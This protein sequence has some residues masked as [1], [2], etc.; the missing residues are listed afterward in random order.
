MTSP[1]VFG[2]G[3]ALSSI[4]CPPDAGKDCVAVGFNSLHGY[5]S[6]V[7]LAE[8]WNIHWRVTATPRPGP[9]AAFSA[10]SCGEPHYCMAVGSYGLSGNAAGDGAFAER[11]N[12][13]S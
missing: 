4:S 6:D 9:N 8:V 13:V 11:W 12:G 10:V 7:P 1:Y 2:Y 5:G 3:D